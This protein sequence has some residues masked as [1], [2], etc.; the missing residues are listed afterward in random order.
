MSAKHDL[1]E[2]FDGEK[3]DEKFVGNRE[4]DYLCYSFVQ[5]SVSQYIL[6]FLYSSLFYADGKATDQHRVFRIPN[7]E[8][9]RDNN[10]KAILCPIEN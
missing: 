4:L 10:L 7:S 1:S 3:F 9:I 6:I 8:F 2:T 5:K